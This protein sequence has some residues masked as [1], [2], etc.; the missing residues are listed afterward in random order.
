MGHMRRWPVESLEY[1]GLCSHNPL[2]EKVSGD[3]DLTTEELEAQAIELQQRQKDLKHK[4]YVKIKSAHPA[5]FNARANKASKTHYKANSSKIIAKALKKQAKKK[6][7]TLK[8]NTWFCAICQHAF[9][10]ESSLTI[11]LTGKKHAR[12]VAKAAANSSF[13]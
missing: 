11:H 5:A 4:S 13:S 8:D 7:A 12:K 1:D 3:H 10:R 2:S 9:T 6:A